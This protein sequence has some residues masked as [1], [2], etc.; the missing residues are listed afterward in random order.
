MD[1]IFKNVHLFIIDHY[2]WHDKVFFFRK[3]RFLARFFKK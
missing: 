3:Y 2:L 1:V